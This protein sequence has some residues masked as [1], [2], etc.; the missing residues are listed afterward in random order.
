MALPLGATYRLGESTGEV[1]AATHP[2]APV[3]VA[4]AVSSVRKGSPPARRTQA[5]GHPPDPPGPPAP[6]AAHEPPSPSLFDDGPTRPA[7]IARRAGEIR[8]LVEQAWV[9]DWAVRMSYTNAKG[10]AQQ[11]N[12]IV[13]DALDE[14]LL[15]EVLPR[16]DRRTLNLARVHWARVLTEAEEDQLL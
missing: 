3:D 12:V 7:H 1:G 6:A 13:T 2:R 9:E 8:D 5:V 10:A 14:Q 15:V 4:A 11:L 16:L